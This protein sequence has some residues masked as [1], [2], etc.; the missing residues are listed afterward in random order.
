MSTRLLD[1]SIDLRKPQSRPLADF[2]GREERLECLGNRFGRHPGTSIGN[3]D[4]HILAGLNFVVHTGISFV[5]MR[6]GGLYGQLAAF[7]HR[8]AGIDGKI[9]EGIFKLVTVRQ[10]GPKSPR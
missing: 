4:S 10:S 3:E 8:V 9:D 1:E 2:F 6:V 7:E 5:E